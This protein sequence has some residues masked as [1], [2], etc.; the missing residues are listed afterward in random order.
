MADT[1]RKSSLVHV[2]RGLTQVVPIIIQ[3]FKH[4]TKEKRSETHTLLKR[5]RI[6]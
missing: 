5:L 6:G 3:I 4:W 1:G 2:L